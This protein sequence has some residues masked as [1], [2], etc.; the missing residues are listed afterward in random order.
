MLGWA[1]Q[2]IGDLHARK[3]E[4]RKMPNRA[5]TG[6]SFGH[7]DCAFYQTGYDE[8]PSYSLDEI[9]GQSS[10][11]EEQVKRYHEMHDL[12]AEMYKFQTPEGKKLPQRDVEEKRKK[13]EEEEE[14][15][16]KKEDSKSEDKSVT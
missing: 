9:S 8:Y 7:D 4:T 3:L 2:D 10:V 11:T 14:K 15:A 16:K 12:F 1:L 6:L 13:K 5:S